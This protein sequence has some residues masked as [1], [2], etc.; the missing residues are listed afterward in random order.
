MKA[1]D[2]K[3]IACQQTTAASRTIRLVYP[4]ATQARD[5]HAVPPCPPQPQCR[6]RLS[7]RNALEREP[8]PTTD[9]D[10]RLFKTSRGT[11][12]MLWLMVHRPMENRSG[13]TVQADL[14][15]ADSRAEHRAAIEMTHP[16]S[17]GSTRRLTLGATHGPRQRQR[18]SRVPAGLRDPACRPKSPPAATPAAPCLTNAASRSRG[19]LA[20]PR[21]SAAWTRRC[22]KGPSASTHG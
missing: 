14:T 1:S 16:H 8:S 20:G 4:Q 6:T 7:G 12:T 18:H 10:A 13:S 19:L 11:G 21:P 5:P 9:P 17:P 3:A 2:P 15:R 22:C